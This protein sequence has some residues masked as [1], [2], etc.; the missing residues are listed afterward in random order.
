MLHKIINFQYTPHSHTRINYM[1][2]A[3]FLI[4]KIR[5]SILNSNFGIENDGSARA[6]YASVKRYKFKTVF[7]LIFNYTDLNSV[8]IFFV[9]PLFGM[10]NF[11]TVFN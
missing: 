9:K 1:L 2:V 10:R 11:K 5:F 3:N 4:L 8:L 6:P 7:F